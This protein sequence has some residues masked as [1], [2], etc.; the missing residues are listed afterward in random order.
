MFIKS[1]SAL[2]LLLH[3]LYF[4]TLFLFLLLLSSLEEGATIETAQDYLFSALRFE[5]IRF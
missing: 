3:V 4:L 5:R 2:L 1:S